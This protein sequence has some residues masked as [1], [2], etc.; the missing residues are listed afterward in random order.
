MGEVKDSIRLRPITV[1]PVKPDL[2]GV[3][4]MNPTRSVMKSNGAQAI[5]GHGRDVPGFKKVKPPGA[6][7]NVLRKTK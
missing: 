7:K 4:K 5:L 1:K 6:K 2:K 3:Y